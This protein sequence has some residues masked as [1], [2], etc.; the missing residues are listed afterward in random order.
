M[1]CT[2]KEI[3]E[4][5]ET[6]NAIGSVVK[7][8]ILNIS[9]FS[10]LGPPDL[11]YL[12]KEAKKPLLGLGKA[13]SPNGYYHYVYG[14]P[15][16]SPA[17]VTTHV[18]NLLNSQE[19]QKGWFSIND[20]KIVRA[21][22]VTYDAFRQI[23]VCIETNLPG[24]T[25]VYGLDK[26]GDK[27]QLINDDIWDSLGVSSVLRAMN[28]VQCPVM[29][30]YGEFFMNRRSIQTFLE[31]VKNL[32]A[33]RID[34]PY[35][36]S[37]YLHHNGSRLLTCVFD[38]LIR[39]RWYHIARELAQTL[40]KI[41][42]SNVIFQSL[43][44][45]SEGKY[46]H[47]I[48]ILSPII[49]LHPTAVVLLYHQGQNFLKLERFDYAL[50]LAKICVQLAPDSFE[51]WM[52]LLEACF[53]SRYFFMALIIMNII[54]LATSD[55][56]LADGGSK[57]D[58][59][60]YDQKSFPKTRPET[61]TRSDTVV[62][63]MVEPTKPDFHH[64]R[65]TTE[66][67]D[68]QLDQ[69]EE[70]RIALDRLLELP[71]AQYTSRQRRV[72]DMLVK[73]ERQIEWEK[74]LALRSELFFIDSD[75]SN[76]RRRGQQKPPAE[77][78]AE[79][80]E[81]NLNVEYKPDHPM[82]DA[83]FI[84]VRESADSN[85]KAFLPRGGD[86]DEEEEEKEENFQ[87]FVKGDRPD[88]TQNAMDVSSNELI[89]KYTSETS[90]ESPKK[91]VTTAAK[92]IPLNLGE[93]FN[94]LFH[95][96]SPT[97]RILQGEY[98][99]GGKRLCS[100]TFDELF[101]SLYEDLAVFYQWKTEEDANARASST[102]SDED[103]KISAKVW[104]MRGILAERLCRVR[105]MEKA[106]RKVVEKG[107]SMYAWHQL[108]KLY[109]TTGNTRAALTCIAEIMDNLEQNGTRDFPV[110]PFW[111]Q[112]EL[113]T[114]IHKKGLAH[115]RAVVKEMSLEDD[116]IEF[117]MAQVTSSWQADGYDK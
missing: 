59:C 49:E 60:E 47:A 90:D 67:Q 106:F 4:I 76:F 14:I 61:L 40:R 16:F 53:Y 109:T 71:A 72:Y 115:V 58:V 78:A 38:F 42:D 25:K 66:S 62:E 94:D 46:S 63:F 23:D 27:I 93:D 102:N 89:K 8:R 43:L 19:K 32:V 50:I 110:L 68:N 34:L 80:I 114:M 51:A 10:V 54:P 64:V 83:S 45:S 18:H 91:P 44:L 31:T 111:I 77:P 107:F 39:R 12:T 82:D 65:L 103:D 6:G 20:H 105:L 24:G 98:E 97:S 2:L 41:N 48:R 52:L 11:C 79:Q 5:V 88:D 37:E 108:L 22:Y 101:Q 57:F 3:I 69:L 28:P 56:L 26:N 36:S 55:T 7:Q 15:A 74:M 73:M 21:L 86:D 112:D 81:V 17:V 35:G 33:K 9:N 75:A 104:L 100:K 13:P 70:N 29:K 116:T 99:K 95:E 87:E 84:A 96:S 85:M 30:F 1:T 117:F 113:Y 92:V